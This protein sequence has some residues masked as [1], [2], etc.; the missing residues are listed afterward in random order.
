VI[1]KRLCRQGTDESRPELSLHQT[2][3]KMTVQSRYLADTDL[4][5]CRLEVKSH[6]DA[7]SPN[8]KAYGVSFLNRYSLM[9]VPQTRHQ[10]ITR[11]CDSYPKIIIAK[12]PTTYPK[13]LGMAL[14]FWR[15]RFLPN[16]RC[17]WICF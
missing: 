4:P 5:L 6:F 9:A 3:T 12:Q 1:S 16:L 11:E 10:S 14:E 8:E 7:L 13:H 15:Q 2:E 17:F